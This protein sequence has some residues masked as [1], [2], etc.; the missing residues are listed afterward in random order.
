[1]PIGS[2]E[3]ESAHRYIIQRRLKLPGAWWTEANA[4]YMLALRLN[5][6]NDEWNAYW[7]TQPLRRLIPHITLNPT[8]L[9]GFD[10]IRSK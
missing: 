2:G 7:A 8:R 3:I 5:R 1:L 4:Q 9:R 6:A 10:P